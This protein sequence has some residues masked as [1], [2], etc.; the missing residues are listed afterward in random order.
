MAVTYCNINSDLIDAYHKIES[1]NQK[2]TLDSTL[3]EQQAGSI[4]RY[5]KSGYIE[6]VFKSG[7]PLDT[8]AD[9]TPDSDEWYYDPAND[10]LL[11]NTSGDIPSTFVIETG[12]DW[13]DFKTRARNDAQEMI[14]GLL[15]SVYATPFQKVITPGESYN[16]RNYDYWIRRATALITCSLIVRK[17]IPEDLQADKLYAEV[18]YPNPEI[19]EAHGI[20]QRLLNGE[21]VLRTQRSAREIGGFNYYEGSSNGTTAYFELTGRHTEASEQ[22]WKVVI[23]GAGVPGAATYK[24]STDNGATYTETGKATNNTGDDVRVHLGSGIYCRFVGTF[25]LNDEI[26][27]QLYPYTDTLS[28]QGVGVISLNRG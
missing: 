4:Y 5:E 1:Y 15:K 18:D 28:V 25:A 21:I 12:L 20:A 14:E 11:V 10:V 8:S 17:V 3:W 6:A 23:D 16:S 22:T 26:T 19:G 9:S 7:L 13:D 2:S 27:I 24:R